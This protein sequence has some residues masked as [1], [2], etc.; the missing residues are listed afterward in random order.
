MLLGFISLLLTVFQGAI[1]KICVAPQYLDNLLPCKRP[2]TEHETSN[3]ST[4]TSH[5]QTAFVSSISGR[6]RRLLAESSHETG[7]SYCARKVTNAFYS[8]VLDS[9]DV[10]VIE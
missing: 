3:S 1:S 7:E 10:W 8:A 9:L 6:A 5:F 4:T 2:A